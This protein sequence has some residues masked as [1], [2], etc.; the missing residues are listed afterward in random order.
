VSFACSGEPSSGG[1]RA[2]SVCRCFKVV[3]EI[4]GLGY[5]DKRSLTDQVGRIGIP[6]S[7]VSTLMRGVGLD[8]RE[9]FSL[10]R[11]DVGSRTR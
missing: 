6:S 5:E 10:A 2:L 1:I 11:R 4:V 9:E 7:S 8:E 3:G